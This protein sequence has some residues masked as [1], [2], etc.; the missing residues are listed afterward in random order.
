M[1]PL[2]RLWLGYIRD[3]VSASSSLPVEQRLMKADYHGA[4]VEVLRSERVETVGVR[5]IVLMEGQETLR[6]VTAEDRVRTLAKRG[7]VFG[8]RVEGADRNG[9]TLLV[10]LYGTQMC[11][12]SAERAARKWKVKH[13]VQL[14]GR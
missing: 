2:H 10:E 5:G 11:F 14:Q 4:L 8:V 9:G 1:L 7:T 3:V 13:T 12:R 6:L